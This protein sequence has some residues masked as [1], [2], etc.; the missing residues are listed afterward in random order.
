M[1]AKQKSL[2]LVEKYFVDFEKQK[3]NPAPSVPALKRKKASDAE[4]GLVKRTF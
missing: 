2:S 4:K 3:A 1:T